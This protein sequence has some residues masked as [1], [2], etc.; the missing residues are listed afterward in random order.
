M[1]KLEKFERSDFD[2]LISW[3]VSEESMVQFSGP[4]FKYPLSHDQLE[5]YVS[6]NNRL[7]YKVIDIENGL[8]IG[9]AELNNIDHHHKSARICRILVGDTNNRNKGYGKAIIKELVRIGFDEL[10]L[11]RL[12][13]GVYDFNKQAIKCYQDCGFEI[14]GLLRDSSKVGDSYWSS[15]NMS[16]LNKAN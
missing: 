10:K 15:Y 1:V 12:D 5:R 7:V 8:V 16:I 9:H 2:R 4:I 13:L 3:I 11:H 6:V 14:E